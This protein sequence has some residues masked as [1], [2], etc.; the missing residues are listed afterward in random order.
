MQLI[1]LQIRSNTVNSLHIRLLFE[2]AVTESYS[3]H[4][5]CTN[6][7]FPLYLD[8]TFCIICKKLISYLGFYILYFPIPI[9]DFTFSRVFFLSQ[10][11]TAH[12]ICSILCPSPALP[13]GHGQRLPTGRTGVATYT[14]LSTQLPVALCR[15]GPNYEQINIHL[16]T[17]SAK[18]HVKTKFFKNINLI[19]QYKVICVHH[20][21]HIRHVESSSHTETN[22]SL[23]H[24]LTK[25]KD[26]TGVRKTIFFILDSA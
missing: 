9:L 1:G 13:A 20:G 23:L 22:I 2:S 21:T 4:T 19:Q 25:H 18:P 11:P 26:K 10:C 17:R 24:V 16:Y 15:P 7:C 14:L 5:L 6:R 8:E 12:A 3:K